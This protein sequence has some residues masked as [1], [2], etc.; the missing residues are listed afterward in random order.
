MRLVCC[1]VCEHVC[2]CVYWV[3]CVGERSAYYGL[4]CAPGIRFALKHLEAAVLDHDKKI[5]KIFRKFRGCYWFL[6]ILLC[7]V[8]YLFVN[9][10]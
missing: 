6:V 8:F 5:I 7:L 3:L 9:S 10:S 1:W 2:V 4:D